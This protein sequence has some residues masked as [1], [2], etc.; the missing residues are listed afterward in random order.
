MQM[1]A[2]SLGTLGIHAPYIYTCIYTYMYII[3]IYIKRYV[4]RGYKGI[5]S[6]FFE[7]SH[8]DLRLRDSGV[9]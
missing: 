1:R 7:K 2:R 9:P 6:S 8:L 5:A 3:Y 4:D